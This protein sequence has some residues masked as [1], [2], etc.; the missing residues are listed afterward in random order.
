MAAID[1][2]IIAA[3][4]AAAASL[5]V[6]IIAYCG[7]RKTQ[8]K[9]ETLKGKLAERKSE[10]DA[11]RD[12]VYEARKRLYQECEP[13]L[14]QFYETGENALHRVYSLARTSRAGDLEPGAS[15]LDGAGYY[16]VSTIYNLLA[17]AAVFKMIQRRLTFIDLG[18][19]SH[20]SAHYFLAK[21]IYLSFTD[22]FDL[23][24]RAPE[25][26]YSPDEPGWE[27]KRMSSPAQ[28]W[29]QHVNLGRLD[30]A[31]EALVVKSSADPERL[32]SFGEFEDAFYDEQSPIGEAFNGFLDLFLSF[33]PRTRPILWRTLVAQAHIYLAL[34][35]LCLDNANAR[36]TGMVYPIPADERTQFDWRA[37]A[38][39]ASNAE[40]LEH[41]FSVSE[42]Y[43]QAHLG[44]QFVVH[45]DQP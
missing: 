11:R 31:V 20:I 27:D 9:V 21:A 45:E 10:N 29:R 1:A 14:F 38:E 43:L 33:H 37:P 26:P 25:L 34:P 40:V 18:V 7:N 22:A 39:N 28:F 8:L 16:M 41:P 15:W 12:Y 5:L 44:K 36:G 23:A 2:D 6:A 35:R 24:A 17:P 13:L 32:C 4:I 42:A 3:Y 19:E 30:V